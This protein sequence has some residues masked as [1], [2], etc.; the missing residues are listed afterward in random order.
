MGML[1]DPASSTFIELAVVGAAAAL[2]RFS[3][4]GT[5]TPAVEGDPA[6]YP[7]TANFAA[8]GG[9][10]DFVAVSDDIVSGD[11]TVCFAVNSAGV[12]TIYAGT[13]YPLRW[14]VVNHG[15]ATVS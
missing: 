5:G 6:F 1:V 3:S 7:D 9:V 2:V 10:F 13:A 14:R 8:Y 15:A 4:T 12:G 11:V